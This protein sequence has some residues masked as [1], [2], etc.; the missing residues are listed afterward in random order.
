MELPIV[1]VHPVIIRCVLRPDL[2]RLNGMETGRVLHK[3]C[4]HVG[5]LKQAVIIAGHAVIPDH[6]PALFNGSLDDIYLNDMITDFL[7]QSRQD[8]FID[9]REHFRIHQIL[10]SRF[11]EALRQTGFIFD[12]PGNFIELHVVLAMEPVRNEVI[13]IGLMWSGN[14]CIQSRQMILMHRPRSSGQQHVDRKSS[15]VGIITF[16]VSGR[17]RDHDPKR[18]VRAVCQEALI[19]TIRVQIQSGMNNCLDDFVGLN[20][21][22]PSKRGH[23][24]KVHLRSRRDAATELLNRIAAILCTEELPIVLHLIS[25]NRR[26]RQAHLI[27]PN[28]IEIGTELLAVNLHIDQPVIII[29]HE[30]PRIIDKEVC[31]QV[32]L[33]KL[34]LDSK[35]IVASQH[36]DFHTVQR[37]ILQLVFK[38]PVFV[39]PEDDSALIELRQRSSETTCQVLLYSS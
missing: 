24:S 26:S 16:A 6:C 36:N 28:R 27:H 37:K 17:L 12:V 10:N 21:I 11:T 39:V 31:G 33:A 38:F 34:L 25:D 22:A 2:M 4:L 3:E 8:T 13:A 19:D 18:L 1:G 35:R 30:R 29:L 9:A 20:V 32:I 15:K 5:N 23:D 14:K 7:H